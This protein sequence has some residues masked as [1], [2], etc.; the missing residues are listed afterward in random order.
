MG[1]VH[2][3][4]S[5]SGS[6]KWAI[7]TAAPGAE[8]GKPNQSSEAARRGT[9]GHQIGE[10]LLRAWLLGEKPD[11][12]AIYTDR[13]MGFPPRESGLGEDWVDRFP[14]STQFE[15]TFTADAELVGAAVGY[16][17]F[18]WQQKELLKAELLVEQKLSIEHIT[19]EEGATGSSD[20]VLLTETTMCVIDLKMGRGK[21]YAYDV[22]EAAS[23]DPI[24]GEVTPPKY[25]MNTQL[26]M[27]ALGAYHEHSLMR[28]IQRVKAI[29]VQPF[30][31][32]AI[33][34]YE[35]SIEELLELGQWLSERAE[36]TR[37]NPEFVPGN[38]QCFF[39][40][41]RFDCKARNAEMLK[42]SVDGFDDVESF[43]AAPPKPLFRPTL[44]Q[45]F[46]KIDAIRH[47]CDDIEAEVNRLLDAGEV[48]IGLDDQPLKLVEG[49]KPAREWT[50]EAQVEEM[51]RKWRLGD[52]M[53]NKKLISPAQ[54]EK[55][56][57]KLHK[58]TRNRR[59]VADKMTREKTPIG[60]TN[61]KRL[62]ELATQRSGKPVPAL[63]SDPRPALTK[64]ASDMPEDDYDL[65]N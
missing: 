62:S 19:G 43:T 45:V 9:C 20:T 57:P 52:L 12:D 22:I 11:A 42:A 37:T 56:A 40:R 27:Y 4:L 21:V 23:A 35:C 44:G 47:W 24:T 60:R 30:V 39:C 33:S 38:K 51:M 10:E 13:V 31:S 17:N 34:E 8:D 61:W 16:A 14:E 49:R 41:A 7:C 36:A 64:S 18:V 32:P 53:W 6:S 5:P 46:G 65:F 48:V 50:D 3:R 58:T 59:P 28:N 29:I 1:L 26:A 2:A 55:M 15:F 63:G 25:R 54:A